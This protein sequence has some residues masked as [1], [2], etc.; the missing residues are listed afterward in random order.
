VGIYVG[1]KIR[2]RAR[3]D[4]IKPV[5]SVARCKMSSIYEALSSFIAVL[6]SYLTILGVFS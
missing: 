2:S 4:L 6:R 5:V 3:I 1:R